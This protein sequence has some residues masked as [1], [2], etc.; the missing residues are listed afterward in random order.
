M[1]SSSFF[2]YSILRTK[3]KSFR[4]RVSVNHPRAALHKKCLLF[5]L[6]QERFAISKRLYKEGLVFIGT[7]RKE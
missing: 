7:E 6:Q 2:D 3:I 5:V 4:L 1:K